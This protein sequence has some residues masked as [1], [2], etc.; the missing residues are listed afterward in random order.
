MKLE[1][2]KWKELTEDEKIASLKRPVIESIEEQ[3][4]VITEIFNEVKSNGDQAIK[5]YT[6]MYDGVEIDNL[7]MSDKEITSAFDRVPNTLIQSIENAIENVKTFHE[8]TFQSDTN[9]VE[10]RTGCLL[11][12]SPSPRDKRQSRMPSSA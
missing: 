6:K 9:K 11:Y 8:K 10:V 12:T 2:I 1:T 4:S 5:R 3:E 7:L